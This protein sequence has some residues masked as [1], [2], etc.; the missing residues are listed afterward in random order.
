MTF[1]C[2]N[3]SKEVKV[4]TWKLAQKKHFCDKA[5][6]REDAHKLLT[7]STYKCKDCEIVFPR[8]EFFFITRKS[9]NKSR[10]PYCSGCATKR[11]QKRWIEHKVGDTA[12]HAIWRENCL[13]GGGDKSLLWYFRM[14]LHS[15]RT[16]TKRKG[17]CPVDLTAE[18]LL[19]LYHKQNGKCYYSGIEMIWNNYGT[20]YGANAPNAMS[21]DRLDPAKGYTKNNV[22]L[23]THAVNT[24]K[25][26]LQ[27]QEFY[28]TC[29]LILETA[30]KRKASK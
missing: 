15:Y 23:C 13:K 28:D 19:A 12:T 16:R 24:M 30:T 27:E 14:H 11:R 20:G 18:G 21:L 17:L 6:W 26:R 8:E 10:V 2:D 7:A 3:C 29:K 9:G 5:C 4:P 22:V 25:L 1:Y